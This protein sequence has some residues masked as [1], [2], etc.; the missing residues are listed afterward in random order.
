MSVVLGNLTLSFSI[1]LVRH[2]E[3]ATTPCEGA[4]EH[5]TRAKNTAGPADGPVDE[6]NNDIVLP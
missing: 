5:N 3:D 4:L 6:L 1:A 2:P